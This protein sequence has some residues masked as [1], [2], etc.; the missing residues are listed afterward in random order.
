VRPVLIVA[1]V[2]GGCVLA[3]ALSPAKSP[4][5]RTPTRALPAPAPDPH[6]PYGAGKAPFAYRP[7]T[8]CSAAS[9]HGG[10]QVGKTGS[11][12][13]TWAPEAF[14]RGQIDP[15]SKAYRVLFNPVSVEMAK[16]LGLGEAHKAAACL[17]CHAVESAT[18]PQTR[19][20][21]LSEG[22]GCGAC[23]GPADK[24]IGIH[25]TPEWKGLSNREKWEKYGF[26]PANNLVARA[27]NCAG[28][29]VGDAE[30]DMNHDF[31]AAGHPRLAFEPAC[32]HF[33]QD[34]RK[35]WTEKA[36][37][38]DFEVRLW[39]VGQAATLRAA[40]NLLAQRAKRAEN[41]DARTPWPEFSG[42]SCYACHQKVGEEALRGTAGT[43]P[44]PAGVPGWEV[45]SN[46]ALGVAAEYCGS[47]YPG[48]N[49]PNLNEVNKLRELL[50]AKRPPGPKAVAAQAAKALAEL[51][52][53]L[54]AMQAADD[55]GSAPVPKGAADRLAHA[56]A[57]NALARGAK[58]EALL[59]DHDWDALA[60]NYL[61]CAAMLHATGGPAANKWG[62]ELET[63]RDHLRFPTPPEGR[64]NS[65]ADLTRGKLDLIRKN[66]ERLRDA[67]APTGGN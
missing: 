44:R 31:I 66:F 27:L 18:E 38:P 1:V 63:L 61:G 16:K 54:A 42:Y 7:A 17:K 13:S 55:R 50:D 30:R 59:R 43:T 4:P 28:C 64:F 8:S 12:H 62:G 39:V 5:D 3:G 37:Q 22:V 49:S 25:Y 23:H 6:A 47:A 20:Q 51:D 45:W 48:L 52:A 11:E 24:W 36:P 29:H 33:Q 15:H 57:A 21:I 56:L 65:P 32:F 41:D 67:T 26:V 40:V 2:F 53:W 9:C 46:T 14:P 10:G 34:Y 19:D 60:A 58:D 35:H